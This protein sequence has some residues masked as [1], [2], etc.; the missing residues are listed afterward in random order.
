MNDNKL[1]IKVLNSSENPKVL[2]F[3]SGIPLKYN[4]MNLNF[5][6]NLNGKKR[7]MSLQGIKKKNEV[8]EVR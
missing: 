6:H 4:S 2:S 8:N 5:S 1:K 3:P 7:K